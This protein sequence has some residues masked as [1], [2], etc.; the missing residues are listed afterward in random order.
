MCIVHTT[1]Q[2]S[3]PGPEHHFIVIS[4]I[5]IRPEREYHTKG[6]IHGL[7]FRIFITKCQP[8]ANIYR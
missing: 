8:G 2:T 6:I 7:P 5:S 3:D 4:Y 1:I